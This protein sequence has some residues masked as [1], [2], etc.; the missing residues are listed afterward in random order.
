MVWE[1]Q[2]P[3]LEKTLMRGA[4]RRTKIVIK[5]GKRKK[6]PISIGRVANLAKRGAGYGED[7]GVVQYNC[8]N[9]QYADLNYL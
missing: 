8:V 1:S 9:Y 2:E 3:V 5:L 6:G 7:A 4:S